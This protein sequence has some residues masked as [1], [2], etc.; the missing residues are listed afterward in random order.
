[1]S[2]NK[3]IIV[4]LILLSIGV[5]S[6]YTTYG[7]EENLTTQEPSNP[8]SNTTLMYS[9]KEGSN[10]EIIVDGNEEKFI[11]ISLKNTYSSTIRYGMYYYM[12]SPTKLPDNVTIAL[13]ED[14]EDLLENTIKPNQTRNISIKITNNSEYVVN[15]IVGA[16]IGFEHGEIEDLVTDGEVLIK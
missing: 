10:K 15:L 11:D 13:S 3:I 6:L 16:L 8:N 7:L 4:L 9:L 5:I 2:K 12:I 14:S 1:M